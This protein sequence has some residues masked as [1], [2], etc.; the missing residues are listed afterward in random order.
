ML[1]IKCNYQ[2]GTLARIFSSDKILF[3]ASCVAIQIPENQSP[4]ISLSGYPSSQLSF[5]M[6]SELILMAETQPKL[7]D[8]LQ[9]RRVDN[10]QQYSTGNA[11]LN[12]K[13]VMAKDLQELL[14]VVDENVKT[15]W[16]MS[17]GDDTQN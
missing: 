17:G 16:V 2:V 15:N 11:K 10:I 14:R 1:C 13:F 4:L 7:K 6:W 12:R 9:I 5:T 8:L 3:S